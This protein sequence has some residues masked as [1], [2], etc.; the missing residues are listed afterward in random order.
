MKEIMIGEWVGQVDLLTFPPPS[1]I[2][3][4]AIWHVNV[5]KKNNKC[6][7]KKKKFKQETTKNIN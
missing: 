7:I 5:R 2:N 3:T 4:M 6:N 1:S